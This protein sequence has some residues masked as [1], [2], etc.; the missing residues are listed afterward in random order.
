MFGVFAIDEILRYQWTPFVGS[1]T[2]C[3]P[4]I[5]H[6]GILGKLTNLSKI[7][8]FG[9][10]NWLK[11]PVFFSEFWA[12]I[13]KHSETSKKILEAQK[14]WDHSNTIYIWYPFLTRPLKK[15]KLLPKK[16]TYLPN[17]P[18]RRRAWDSVTQ[19]V[20]V[21]REKFNIDFWFQNFFLTSQ[22]ILG[23]PKKIGRKTQC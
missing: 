7:A 8:L 18:N 11:W 17:L 5:P 2:L 1:R 6:D 20:W 19:R 22:H 21:Y 13:L 4:G 9:H 15:K 3:H 16:G 23:L 14:T 10:D 12:K